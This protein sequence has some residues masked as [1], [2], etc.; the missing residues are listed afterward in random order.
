MTV[1]KEFDLYYLKLII[2]GDIIKQDGVFI[3]LTVNPYQVRTQDLCKGE[4]KPDFADIVQ[5]N[6]GNKIIRPVP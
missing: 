2:L 3:K 5:R 1:K 4:S 6:L